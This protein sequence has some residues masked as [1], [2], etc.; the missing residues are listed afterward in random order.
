[1][2]FLLRRANHPHVLTLTTFENYCWTLILMLKE[3]LIRNYFGTPFIRMTTF[4]LDFTQKVPCHSINT[5]KLTLIP[6]IR[7]NIWIL[8][9]PMVLAIT[10]DW[11]LTCLAF[12][13]VFKDIVAYAT[14]KFTKKCFNMA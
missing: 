1:M 2:R 8:L 10:T 6:A 7:T 3:L 12:N 9:K 5:V 4:E 13:W 11:F 14:Y